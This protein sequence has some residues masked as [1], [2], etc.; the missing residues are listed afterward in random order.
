[1]A[2]VKSVVL[3]EAERTAL[4]KGARDGKTFAFRKRCSMILL[5]AE[6]RTSKEVIKEIGGCEV[7]STTGSNATRNRV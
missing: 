1:M 6:G 3:S 5:K 4:E 7:W 2:K